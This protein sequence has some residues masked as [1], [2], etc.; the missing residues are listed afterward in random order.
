MITKVIYISAGISSL[1]KKV[2]YSKHPILQ[3][4]QRNEKLRYLWLIDV[5][6][7]GF[8]FSLHQILLKAD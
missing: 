4:I 1:S 2:I 7:P 5:Y 8:F 6:R 3:T